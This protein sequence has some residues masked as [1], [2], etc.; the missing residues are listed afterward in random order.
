MEAGKVKVKKVKVTLQ[1]A[2]KVQIKDPK[3][4]NNVIH[5]ST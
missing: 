3:T 2:M 5:H 4:N 1:Q